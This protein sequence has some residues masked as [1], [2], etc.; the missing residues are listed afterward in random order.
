VVAGLQ[1][2]FEGAKLLVV[3]GALCEHHAALRVHGHVGRQRARLQVVGHDGVDHLAVGSQVWV[4]SADLGDGSAGWV[5]F[6][7]VD[8]IGSLVENRSV[9]VD[10]GDA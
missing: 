4:A 3:E 8:H 6:C 7:H 5:V 9:V 10:I 2:Q 1:R